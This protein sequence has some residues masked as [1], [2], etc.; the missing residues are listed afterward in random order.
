MRPLLTIPALAL[1][2][3]CAEPAPVPQ[4]AAWSGGP[5]RDEATFRREV[6]GR[7]LTIENDDVTAFAMIGTDGSFSAGADRNGQILNRLEGTWSWEGGE[8]CRT[9]EV[10]EGATNAPL[11]DCQPVEKTGND[12]TFREPGRTLTW[13][14]SES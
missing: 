8:F 12:V 5:I 7:T 14:V 2:A 10:V 6:A 3:A 4:A 11:S 9:F 1:L 13:T